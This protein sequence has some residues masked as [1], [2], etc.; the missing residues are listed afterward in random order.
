M[1]RE[2]I[3]DL[4]GDEGQSFF[5]ETGTYEGENCSRN[6]NECHGAD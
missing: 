2:G 4:H 1:F 5:G 3:R 6:G